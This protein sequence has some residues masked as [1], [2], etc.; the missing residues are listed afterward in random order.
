MI[1]DL[2]RFVDEEEKYW[3]ELDSLVQRQENE[4]LRRLDLAEVRRFVYLYRRASAG[5]SRV[6]GFPADSG[7]RRYLES[8]VS[9]AYAQ[10]H[11]ARNEGGRLHPLR[12]FFGVFPSTFRRHGTAFLLSLAITLLGA[13]TG[14]VL[15]AVDREAKSVLMPYS[16][17]QTSPAERVAQE[18][19]AGGAG[20]DRLKGQKSIFSA[21]LMT[22]NTRVSLFV[23]AMGLSWGVGTAILLFYNG[24]LLGAVAIDYVAAGQTPFLLGW[25]LPHGVIEIPA[26][27]VA[28]QAGFV[29]AGALIGRGTRA[30][31]RAR[32]RRAGPDLVTLLVG[33]SVML[34]WAGVVE[35]FFSQYHEPVLPYAVKIAFGIAELSGLALFFGL[36]GRAKEVFR[37]KDE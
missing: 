14:A 15:L 16:H 24:V 6:S 5:L 3:K 37:G 8:L 9:R 17:L 13:G 1:I 12:W 36:S 33:L 27:L 35:A 7:I 20:Q 29:L 18:E 32:L 4:P 11:E 25:L 30:T 21:F 10:V 2:E 34:V 26:V 22:H 31:L 23:F 19:K 28:G